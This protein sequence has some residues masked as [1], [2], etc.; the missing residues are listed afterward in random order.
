MFARTGIGEL[1]GAKL[2][3]NISDAED[4]DRASVNDTTLIR[5]EGNSSW[6]WHGLVGRATSTIGHVATLGIVARRLLRSMKV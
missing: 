3:A 6:S 2:T 1:I 4:T 5:Q